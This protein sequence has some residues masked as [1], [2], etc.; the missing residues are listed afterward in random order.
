MSRIDHPDQMKILLLED[1]VRLAGLITR[2]LRRDGNAVD[3]SGTVEDARWLAAES[4]Y[5]VLVLDV[6]LP[7]GDGFALCRE[8]RAG[9][10]WTPVLL[11]TARD[12]IDDRVRGLD[13]GADDYLVKPFAFAELFARLRALARRGSTERPNVLASGDLR[14]DPAT[15]QVSVGREPITLAGREFTLLEYF[16]RHEG[17]VLSRSRIIDEVWD[18]AFEGTPRIIDVYVRALRSRLGEGAGTPRIETIR[19]VG[20]ALRGPTVAPAAARAV[21]Q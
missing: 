11:L 20:Y 2:G 16:L 8:L 14:L 19:G 12:A 9:G 21:G 10:N 13:V 7:D 18:W 1:D 17:E 6:M 3:T 15:R 4:V 5:D